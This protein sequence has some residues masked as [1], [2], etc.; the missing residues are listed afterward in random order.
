MAH[1]G[2][3]VSPDNGWHRC[4]ECY[5]PVPARVKIC[6]NCKSFQD[7]RRYAAI[8][9]VNLALI[10]A[11][12]SV[13]TAAIPAIIY[14]ITSSKADIRISLIPKVD[15]VEILATNQGRRAGAILDAFLVISGTDENDKKRIS[16]VPIQRSAPESQ[17]SKL[18][19]PTEWI[20]LSY[21]NHGGGSD[22]TR[23]LIIKKD[24]VCQLEV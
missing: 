16:K 10:V 20:A 8:G 18:L 1:Q 22:L 24:A 4:P 6:P 17:N 15:S 11:F 21:E 5:E 9:Q 13:L 19:K 7:W 23:S 12:I 14:I 2:A 3:V